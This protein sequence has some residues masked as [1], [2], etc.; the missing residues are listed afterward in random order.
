MGEWGGRV[1]RRGIAAAVC[2]MLLAACQGTGTATSS[3]PGSAAPGWRLVTVGDSIPFAQTDCGGCPSFTTLFAAAVQRD[4]AKTV[5]AQNLSSHDNLT[6]AR[7]LDRIR[8]D[9]AVRAAVRAADIVVVTIG[10]N[11]TPWNA[12][13]DACD[14]N[15]PDGVFNWSLYSGACVTELATRHGTELDGILTEIENL[16]RGMPTAVRV[17][18][19]YN[20][21]IGWDQAPAEAVAPSIEVLEALHAETCRVAEL[22]HAICV[23]VY[24][25]FNGPDGRT[26]AGSLLASDYTHPSATGQERIAQLLEAAGL[27][28]LA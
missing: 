8:N 13:D 26:A 6:G 5:D 28:P 14:G 22:H 27:A 20:D 17:T 25:S 19:D 3:P 24:R 16:R 9:G 1:W 15:N 12:V 4:S 21:V 23:D 11:D 7:L 2:V 18:T 10:H